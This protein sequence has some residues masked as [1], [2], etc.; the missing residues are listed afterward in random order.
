M[1]RLGIALVLLVC[2]CQGIRGPFDARS[3]RRV[4]DP[5][6]PTYE[7][8]QRGRDRYP[9]PDES[10]TIAPNSGAAG[11]IATPNYFLKEN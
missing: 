5:N 11:M 3:P 7:Q 9:F 1:R 2:G 10:A 4:D 6:L 8:E